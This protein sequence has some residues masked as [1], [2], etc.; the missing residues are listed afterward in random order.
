MAL[1][2]ALD[3]KGVLAGEFDL[4]ILLVDAGKLAFELV[5]VLAL[6]HIEARLEGPDALSKL[7]AADRSP[8]RHT[9]EVVYKTEDWCELVRGEAWYGE[10]HVA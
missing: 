9:A 8:V 6:S 7:W 3:A 10:R 5:A 1:S 4:D 2:A